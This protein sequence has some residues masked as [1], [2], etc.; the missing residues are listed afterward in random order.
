MVAVAGNSLGFVAHAGLAGCKRQKSPPVRATSK[1]GR[2]FAGVCPSASPACIVDVR[3]GSFGKQALSPRRC[4][5]LHDPFKTRVQMI[6][7]AHSP[8][9]ALARPQ[10]LP[11]Q[12]LTDYFA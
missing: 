7:D 8:R 12:H 1:F 4:E 10:A 5:K 9:V 3:H 11:A 2:Y 6:R